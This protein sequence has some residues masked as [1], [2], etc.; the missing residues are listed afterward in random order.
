MQHTWYDG[1]AQLDDLVQGV[2]AMGVLDDG[3]ER[4]DPLDGPEETENLL[5]SNENQLSTSINCVHNCFDD[6]TLQ[7]GRV[8][9]DVYRDEHG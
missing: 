9:E 8:H 7:G 1:G 2:D 3:G 5:F 4:P 6:G